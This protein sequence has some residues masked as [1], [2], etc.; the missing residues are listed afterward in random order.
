GH[1]HAAR[2]GHNPGVGRRNVG[3]ALGFEQ[4]LRDVIR[5]RSSLEFQALLLGAGRGHVG[6]ARAGG[7]R[8]QRHA[9]L[10]KVPAP[11][12]QPGAEARI[13]QVEAGGAA[14]LA[15]KLGHAVFE[16]VAEIRVVG[17]ERGLAGLG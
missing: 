15:L 6:P 4:R 10:F 9:L 11:L 14:L 5:R 8:F 1:R 12:A 7:G 3:H 2:I 13:R 16:V 17:R